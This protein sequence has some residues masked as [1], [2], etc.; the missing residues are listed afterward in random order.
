M[1][2]WLS[3]PCLATLATLASAQRAAELVPTPAQPLVVQAHADG[4]ALEGLLD[5][6]CALFGWCWTADADVLELLREHSESCAVWLPGL[7]VEPQRVHGFVGGLLQACGLALARAEIGSHVLL[8]LTASDPPYAES[9]VGTPVLVDAG[10]LDEVAPLG[11]LRCA[12]LLDQPLHYGAEGAQ[13]VSTLTAGSRLEFDAPLGSTQ[14]L[15]GPAAGLARMPGLL[16]IVARNSSL[17]LAASLWPA[18]G[19]ASAALPDS[20]LS[21]AALFPPREGVPPGEMRGEIAPASWFAELRAAAPALAPLPVEFE[22]GFRELHAF[23]RP[24]WTLAAQERATLA[25]TLLLVHGRVIDLERAEDGSVVRLLVRRWPDQTRTGEPTVPPFVR[26]EE[27]ER[28]RAHPALR[29]RTRL[30]LVHLQREATERW[31][32]SL[33]HCGEWGAPSSARFVDEGRL[34]E[35][36]GPLSVVRALADWLVRA[37]QL[38]AR[39]GY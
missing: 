1:H 14:L 5:S 27:L 4:N 26:A 35:I 23:V 25:E 33:F 18:A 8:V 22:P 13:F 37:D 19:A 20:D 38:N 6:Y 31:L 39:R 7:R 17:E 2:P 30:S 36:S 24:G 32:A 15:V 11:V 28:W 16:A 21:C 12:S 3:I 29:V 34:L 10:E 9:F